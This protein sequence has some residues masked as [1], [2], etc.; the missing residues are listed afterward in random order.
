[1]TDHSF[2]GAHT[3]VKLKIIKDYLSIYTNALKNQPFKLIYIDAFAGTGERVEVLPAA[4]VFGKG[5]L[6][7]KYRG[8][9]QIALELQN[10]FDIYYFIEKD[11]KHFTKL[12]EIVSP[13]K[14]SR[15]IHCYNDDANEVIP[16]ICKGINWKQHRA[17]LFLDP[18]GMAVEWSTLDII[19]NTEAIDVWYLFPTFG[20]YRNISNTLE[21]TER[22]KQD[23]LTTLFGTEDWKE[24]VFRTKN[25]SRSP[26]Q[27]DMF[28]TFCGHAD[29]KAEK[30]V[31][32][33]GLEEYTKM[34]FEKLF[35]YVTSPVRLYSQ[36]GV[37]SFSL[38]MLLSNTRLTAINLAKKIANHILKSS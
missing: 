14:A 35:P 10:A 25:N 26:E 5:E 11:K 37:H 6:K 23:K 24:Y 27:D 28:N 4:P 15:S 36:K 1:M 18:Y 32:L 20:A 12:K 2:G 31:D 3:E 7:N 33:S 34:R 8:S 38:F 16:T 13:Y 22:Y 29:V 21:D 9:V 17:V 30:A 19:K